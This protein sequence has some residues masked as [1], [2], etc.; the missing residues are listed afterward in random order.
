MRRK[1]KYN[2]KKKKI[3]TLPNIK[4]KFSKSSSGKFSTLKLQKK[5]AT[6]FPLIF[7]NRI[8]TEFQMWKV[9]G[10]IKDGGIEITF[11]L[12]TIC[13]NFEKIIFFIYFSHANNDW[14]EAFG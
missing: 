8:S 7:S 10:L 5:N 9:S 12:R 14:S 11:S 2:K 4:N 13:R 6:F 1:T 3:S